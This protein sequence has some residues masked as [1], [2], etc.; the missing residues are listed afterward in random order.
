MVGPSK[1]GS[2]STLT[3]RQNISLE[4]PETVHIWLPLKTTKMYAGKAVLVIGGSSGLGLA[5]AKEIKRRGGIVTI[6]SRSISKLEQYKPEYKVTAID[7]TEEKSV[8]KISTEFD[9]VFCCPGFAVPSSAQDISAEVTEKIMKCNFFGAVR[10]YSHFLK[11]VSETNR[12]SLVFVASTLALHAFSGYGMYAPSKAALSSFY[13][14]VHEESAILGL[15]TYIYYVSTIL[16]PG[17]EEEEKIKPVATK[18]IE[19]AS[20][21]LSAR[22]ENRARTLLDEMRCNRVIYSD[23]VTRMFSKASDIRSVSDVLAWIAAPLFWCAFKL[24]CTYII[25]RECRKNV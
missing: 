14:A 10:V 22:P 20:R 17:F 23:F 24:Y 12:K 1:S 8:R 11:A 3:S 4:T 5:L 15:D 9:M 25:R 21:T 16:S 6:S 13:E 19:G 2:F 7:I 18:K